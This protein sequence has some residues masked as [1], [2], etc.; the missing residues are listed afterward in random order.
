M[1]KIALWILVLLMI[2]STVPS[3]E[4]DSDLIETPGGNLEITFI[5]HASLI[6]D[7]SG[8]VIHVDPW[9]RQ[10]DYESLPKAD[11]ILITHDHRDHLD[12]AAVRD[13]QTGE[14]ITILTQ[15]CAEKG[16]AG[17]V[18]ENGDTT[19]V[20]GI[21]IIAVPAYNIE[22][23]R[24]DGSPFHPKGDGN[25]YLLRFGDMKVYVAGDTEPIPEMSALSGVD[26]AFLPMNLPYTMSP[27]M[28][29]EA[30][31]VIE[32]RILYPYHYGDSDTERLVKLLEDTP[33]IEVRVRK[34]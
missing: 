11:I 1:Y 4:H 27:D 21:E 29:A 31:R 24:D 20:R 19:T 26:I 22:H 2:P 17:I 14:T 16:F 30:A 15:L 6:F 8:V 28:A 32:P 13:V 25:G 34:M 10:G 5:G 23:K 7:Y 9:S 3:R 33:S 18:L 12:G